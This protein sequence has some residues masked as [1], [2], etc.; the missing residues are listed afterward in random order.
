M[1]L[2]RQMQVIMETGIDLTLVSSPGPDLD[3]IART[4]SVRCHPIP[5]S[6]TPNPVRDLVSLFKLMLFFFQERFDIVHS[7]TPKAGLLSALAGRLA[8]TSVRIHTYTGQPWVELRGPVRWIA[9]QS[10]RLIALLDTRTYADSVSQRDFLIAEGLVDPIKIKV[11]GAGSIS[12]VDLRRFDPAIGRTR[13]AGLRHQLGIPTTSLVIIFVGRVTKDKGVVELISAFHQLHEQYHDSY[14][15][16]VGQLEPERDPLPGPILDDISTNP[17]IR[18][19]GFVFDPENYFAA[20]DIFCLP[21]YREGFGSVVIEAGAM[22]LPTVATG[23]TGLVDSV[24]D[25]VTGL[26]VPPKNVSALFAALLTLIQSP[27]LRQ[28]MGLAA[29]RRA[30]EHFDA[31]RVNQTLIDEYYRLVNVERLGP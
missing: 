22:N 8:R 24:V 15:L 16:L 18:S 6:R 1:L 28:R 29:R 26:L 7:S 12:G 10:D 21:S 9:R 14:L 5:M 2:R 25:G 13:R 17:H 11:L 20:S 30:L 4:L 27:D 19:F 23:V 31:A 3:E